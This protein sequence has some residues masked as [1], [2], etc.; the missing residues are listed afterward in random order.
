[1]YTETRF[2]GENQKNMSSPDPDLRDEREISAV[3]THAEL[4]DNVH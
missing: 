3:S 4:K 1:M 2:P